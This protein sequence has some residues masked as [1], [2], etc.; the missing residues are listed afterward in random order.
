M[1]LCVGALESSEFHRQSRLIRSAWPQ[2][3]GETIAAP[4]RH[5]LDVVDDL[6][7]ADSPLYVAA[8]RMMGL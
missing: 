5:H 6:T 7:R 4:G 8:A 3:P 1:H 2:C